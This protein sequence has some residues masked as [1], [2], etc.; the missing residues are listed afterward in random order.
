MILF[1]TPRDLAL[2]SVYLVVAID[3]LGS[4]LTVPV[5]P[6]FVEAVCG[7]SEQGTCV[8]LYCSRLGGS[9]SSLGVLF[10]S[11]AVAQLCSS[12]WMGPL[13][14]RIG[15]RRIMIVSL[16]GSG[17]G[18]LAS[19]LAPNFVLLLAARLFIG[20][21]SGTMSAANAYM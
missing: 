10:S 18:M 5:M 6:F 20:S 11:F 2:L 13:S 3:M 15:R 1:K 4:A 12:A 9:V 7:C 16:V 8:D 19:S 21:C 17:I 14:D